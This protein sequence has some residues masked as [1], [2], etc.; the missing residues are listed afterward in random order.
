M[1]QCKCTFITVLP[2]Q[3]TTESKYSKIA[4]KI[5][6]GLGHEMNSHSLAKIDTSKIEIGNSFELLRCASED[7]SFLPFST[8]LS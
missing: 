4:K 2:S 8:L 7:L 6:N 3:C 5:L 1:N